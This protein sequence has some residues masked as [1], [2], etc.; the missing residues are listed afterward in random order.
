[1]RE[2]QKEANLSIWFSAVSHRND[3]DEVS[4]N[5]VPAPCN[6]IDDLFD[7]VILLQP[8]SNGESKIY[9]NILKDETGCVEPGKTL[10]LD[11]TSLLVQ[12]ATF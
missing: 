8:E 11:P 4:D 9:L 7:T 10:R 6:E 12:G 3:K 5:G 1:M 2:L